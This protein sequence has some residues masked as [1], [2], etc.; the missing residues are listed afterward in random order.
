MANAHLPN[1]H[2]DVTP[3]WQPTSPPPVKFLEAIN[4]I[5]VQGFNGCRFSGFVPAFWCSNGKNDVFAVRTLAFTEINQASQLAGRM[6]AAHGGFC[7]ATLLGAAQN[8][9][10]AK[11][12]SNVRP[13]PSHLHIEYL[14]PMPQGPFH[15]VVK[16]M[17]AGNRSVSLQA[18]LISPHTEQAILYATALIR[19]GYQQDGRRSD[20]IQ[21]PI[22]RLPDRVAECDR[23]SSAF[24]YAV[25]PPISSVRFF[26]PN[27]GSTLFWSP[28]FGGQHA[29]DQWAKLDDGGMFQVEH[30]P[31][32]V[33]L[34][35]IIPLN[36]EP[37]P[38]TA[39]TRFKLPT[40]S[41]SINFC[42][43]VKDE[44][45]LLVRTTMQKLASGRVDMNIHVINDAGNLVA[46]CVQICAVIP[47]A[48]QRK[49]TTSV[50]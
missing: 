22:P 19:L 11:Q 15:I 20:E 3:G 45:W 27:D 8:Y 37:D 24:C 29:R 13:A 38:Y 17:H 12:E 33:D 18:E 36:Y 25:N 34:I 23:W 39:P 50:L 7:A 6:L 40:M 5:P 16:P 43:T 28:S 35:P 26:C 4:T 48:A 31:L 1:S 14:C 21:P 46:T 30:I 42:G 9:F 41:I 44:E 49:P 2:P 10:M 32:L 47:K